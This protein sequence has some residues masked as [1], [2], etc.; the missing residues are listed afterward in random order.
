MLAHKKKTKYICN[1]KKKT[2]TNSEKIME[3]KRV[4]KWEITI[5]LIVGTEIK[6][7]VE[8][9]SIKKAIG[10]IEYTVKKLNSKIVKVE[11]ITTGKDTPD[12]YAG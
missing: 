10:Q 12:G 11:R 4:W 3:T 9:E 6:T 1:I 7:V 5:K 2:I 8:A